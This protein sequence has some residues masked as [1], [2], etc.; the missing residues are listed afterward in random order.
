MKLPLTLI[1]ISI[2]FDHSSLFFVCVFYLSCA[3]YFVEE[4]S[5]SR[6]FDYKC[7]TFNCFEVRIDYRLRA[8]TKRSVS[9]QKNSS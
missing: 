5:L 7:I 6:S 1:K 3:E 4:N 2:I 8:E 9:M